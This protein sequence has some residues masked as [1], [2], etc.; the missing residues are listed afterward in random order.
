[1]T[2]R[3]FQ[4]TDTQLLTERPASYADIAYDVIADSIFSGEFPVGSRLVMD[5]LAERLIMSRTP[6]RD[7][8]RKLAQEGVLESAGRRG[9]VVRSPDAEEIRQTFEAREMIEAAAARIAA[10]SGARAAEHVREAITRAQNCDVATPFGSYE[11]NR[12]V[13]RAVVEA[14]GNDILLEFFDALWKRGRSHS[15]YAKCFV[16]VG[17]AEAVGTKHADILR[18]LAAGDPDAAEIEAR[19][20]VRAGLRLHGIATTAHT[21]TA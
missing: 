14:T 11:A 9:Y 15:L 7:A 17:G 19:E 2:L 3:G 12:I 21:S 6:V 13:H 16:D 20:H 8:L 4:V 5:N 1:M 18:A 10:G